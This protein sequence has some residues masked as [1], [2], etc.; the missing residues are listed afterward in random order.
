MHAHKQKQKHQKPN[1]QH[2]KLRLLVVSKY[3]I[4]EQVAAGPGQVRRSV[5][6]KHEE[7]LRLPKARPRVGKHAMPTNIFVHTADR[8][9]WRKKNTMKIENPPFWMKTRK[10]KRDKQ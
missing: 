8:L 4:P 10:T 6:H 3:R 2:K 7:G 9:K 5:R 1:P